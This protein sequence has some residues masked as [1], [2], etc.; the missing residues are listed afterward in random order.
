MLRFGRSQA[1]GP[2][3]TYWDDTDRG[4]AKNLLTMWTN[5]AKMKNPTPDDS[6]GFVW[7]KVG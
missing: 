3:R 5:F 1:L 6:L 7:T 4:V 2:I